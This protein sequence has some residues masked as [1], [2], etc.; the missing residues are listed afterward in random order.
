[1]IRGSKLSTRMKN[2][3]SAFITDKDIVKAY[4][5]L[6]LSNAD[7]IKKLQELSKKA[8]DKIESKDTW[9]ISDSSSSFKSFNLTKYGK[10]E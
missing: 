7:D 9:I 5:K 3:K 2:K 6:G 8:D 1:M 4:K 10:L